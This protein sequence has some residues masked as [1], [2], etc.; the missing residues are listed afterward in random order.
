MRRA[1]LAVV[2]LALA[3][4][5][6][7]PGRPAPKGAMSE[8]EKAFC[9]PE[10]EVVEKRRAIFQAQGLSPAEIAKKNEV[11]EQALAECRRHWVI[12]ARSE[13]ER[14]ADALEAERRAGKNATDIERARVL[15]EIRM[16]RLA[17]RRPSE[18]TS[19]ERAEL[20]SGLQAETAETRAALDAAHA[21]DP[22]FMRQVHSALV[23]YH[24]GRR[25]T[26]QAE[27]DAEGAR[28]AQGEG[29]RTRFYALQSELT[30]SDEVLA[31]ATEA[32]GDGLA[33]CSD[34]RVAAV[35]R[36][37]GLRFEGAKPD[38]ACDGDEVQQYVR[39]VK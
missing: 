7:S 32:G 27:I 17:S 26:L 36:C 4:L 15:Q 18:L 33:P 3:T 23:C 25:R 38:A 37:L 28:I 10:I 13:Q 1:A 12:E 31:R 22:A 19:A 6:A 16:E 11:D 20:A 21:R 39:L 8:A 5:A 29:D 30:R 34:A 24:G 35:A 9:A 2:P 14:K